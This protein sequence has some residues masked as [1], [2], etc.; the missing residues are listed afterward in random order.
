VTAT[1]ATLPDPEAVS[2]RVL[3]VDDSEDNRRLLAHFLKGAGAEV[4]QAC[5]GEEA[6]H[7]IQQEMAR[8]GSFHTVLM[9]MQM[10][11]CDGYEAT[12]RARDIGYRGAIIAL[13]AH[14]LSEE[15]GKCIA[16]GCDDF[17][18]KPIERSK[19]CGAVLTWAHRSHKELA[20]E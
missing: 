7:H 5:E 2:L 20:P 15:R 4:V 9:D 19:L 8:R 14:A 13:T 17:L 18:N 16:A 1:R 11:V 10:P 6:L 3:L 12:R